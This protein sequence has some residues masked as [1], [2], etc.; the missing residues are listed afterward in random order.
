MLVRLDEF[1]IVPAAPF[2][3]LV[4]IYEKSS[5]FYNIVVRKTRKIIGAQG[6]NAQKFARLVQFPQLDIDLVLLDRRA[7]V[8]CEIRRSVHDRGLFN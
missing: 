8:R 7:S 3:L 5:L 4:A 1:P 2:E 6:N